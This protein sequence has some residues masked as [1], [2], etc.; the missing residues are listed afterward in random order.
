MGII[1]ISLLLFQLSCEDD[2]VPDDKEIVNVVHVHT[3]PF[4]A[5]SR[6]LCHHR[7]MEMVR[8]SGKVRYFGMNILQSPPAP[9]NFAGV[10]GVHV[11]LADY[12]FSKRFNVRTNKEGYWTMHLV[13]PRGM[14]LD[15][16]FMYEKDH[17]SKEVERMVIPGGLPSGYDKSVIKSNVYSIGSEDIADIAMQMPDELFLF[18]AKSTLEQR[19]YELTGIAYVI[20]NLAVA[21]VGKAWASIYNP[22]LPHGDPGAS[23]IA[24][25][26]VSSPLGGPIYFDETV[27]PNPMISAT[28]V[29]GGVLLNNLSF[30]VHSLT[31]VKAPFAYNTIQFVVDDSAKLYVASPPHA[32]MGNNACGPGA[33]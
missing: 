32:I 24:N 1:L 31:A 26:P 21:T 11:W 28:S 16:S 14:D 4:A 19:I 3:G 5:T 18:V 6:E 33:P 22:T 8:L 17:F 12:P 10:P 13:K 29:D 25:P 20:H 2:T 23:V 9:Y 30:G 7:G 15:L 27:T